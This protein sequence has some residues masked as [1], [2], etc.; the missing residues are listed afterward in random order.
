MSLIVFA[1]MSAVVF[2]AVSLPVSETSAGKWRTVTQADTKVLLKNW[3]DELPCTYRDGG[4]NPSYAVKRI[5]VF[6]PTVP[7][8]QGERTFVQVLEL[9]PG[10]YWRGGYSRDIRKHTV[11][12]RSKG[13][14]ADF[15]SAGFPE[16]Q[17]FDCYNDSRC[18]FR[19]IRFAIDGKPCQ[20]IHFN[21][22]I[23]NMDHF[24]GAGTAPFNLL[25]VHCGAAK[26]FT[27]AHF[28]L[29]G[30]RLAITFPGASDEVG[31]VPARRNGPF[32]AADEKICRLALNGAL[33][34][35]QTEGFQ[36]YVGVA[37]RRGL[38]VADCRV[39]LE[40]AVAKDSTGKS[41][42][43][44]PSGGPGGGFTDCFDNPQKCK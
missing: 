31:S 30:K 2:A 44:V 22:D 43:A 12:N 6:C 5:N 34:A 29:K 33:S 7:Q 9:Q 18:Q 15:K 35:W 42:V 17:D 26:P 21:P 16:G 11:F 27:R 24:Y 37:K 32:V 3:P 10:F 40:Q 41:A 4:Y 14:F 36:E 13:Y 28:R 23:G 19:N 38:S 39:V 1:A 8:H 20:W 25:L